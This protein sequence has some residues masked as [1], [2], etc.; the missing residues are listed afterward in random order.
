MIFRI[1]QVFGMGNQGRNKMLFCSI[2]PYFEKI[3]DIT[4]FKNSA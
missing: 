3:Y 2:C 4:M 1:I